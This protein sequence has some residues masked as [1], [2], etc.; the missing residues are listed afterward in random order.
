M[1]LLL[2]TPHVFFALG[3]GDIVKRVQLI[4]GNL[5]IR[6]VNE[7]DVGKFTCKA[8]QKS[9][10]YTLLLVASSKHK[11]QEKYIYE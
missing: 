1:L 5:G 10:E 11:T 8:D 2:I 7:K 3:K 4:R 6:G 9:Q